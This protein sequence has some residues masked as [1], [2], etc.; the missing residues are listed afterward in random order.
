MGIGLEELAPLYV[1][2]AIRGFGPKKFKEIYA[3]GLSPQEVIELPDRL[4]IKGKTGD[5]LREQLRSIPRKTLDECRSRAEKQL[6]ACENKGARIITYEDPLYPPNVYRSNNPTPVLYARGAAD[7]LKNPCVVAVVGSRNIRPPYSERQADFTKTACRFGFSIVSGFALGADTIGHRTAHECGGRTICVMPGGLDRPFPP[8]NRD[9]WDLFLEY[10][11]AVF[12]SE[13]AF[14]VRASALTL[15]K[16]NKLIV[17]F[18]RGVL[19][20]QSSEK[21]GAMN[22]HRFGKEQKKEV[23]TF[24]DDGT[25]D[26]LGNRQIA[27]DLKTGGVSFS[28][29]RPSINEYEQWLRML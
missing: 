26:T 25:N 13:F 29:T 8:E 4:P 18:A 11:R 17:A 24:C 12:V 27:E 9:L 1:L 20:G 14:G 16:R 21:G 19:V 3:V 23:A 6:A 22:A 7:V 5:K 2:D 10:S 15:R 28:S